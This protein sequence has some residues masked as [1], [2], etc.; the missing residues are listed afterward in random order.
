M[1]F[2][3][4]AFIFLLFSTGNLATAIL[5]KYIIP[6]L[7]FF[8]YKEIAQQFN[9]P[10]FL[11]SFANFDGAHYLLIAKNGYTTYQQAF[12]PLYPLL[13]RWLSPLFSNNLLLTGLIISNLSFLLGLYIFS[14]YLK[15]T[16]NN[17]QL[18]VWVIIFLLV[19]PTSF[20]FAAVY[21]EGLSFLL[22]ISTL[23]FLKKEKYGASSIF[24]I[25][26]NKELK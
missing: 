14:K 16:T 25:L 24:A 6:Y 21:T 17:Q 22:F 2:K 19:F 18:T 26:E 7:G 23:Y 5:A 8:P 12:F 13:I 9:L 3:I 15:L 20:F 11:T 1:R 4:I 10:S